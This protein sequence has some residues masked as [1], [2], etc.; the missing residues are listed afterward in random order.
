M[1]SFLSPNTPPPLLSPADKKQANKTQGQRIVQNYFNTPNKFI[2]PYL[3]NQK[4]KQ[5]L[6]QQINKITIP[7][8]DLLRIIKKI[9]KNKDLNENLEWKKFRNW[10]LA[11]QKSNPIYNRLY[12]K[13][14]NTI[15][16]LKKKV[17]K[18]KVQQKPRHNKDNKITE[19][20][21]LYLKFMTNI[22]SFNQADE[23]QI[24]QL[25]TKI[26]SD[27]EAYKQTKSL[28]QHFKET[29]TRSKKNNQH[30]PKS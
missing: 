29:Y 20:N 4:I 6:I 16:I 8:Q 7:S 10:Y 5:S 26:Q 23:N 22:V 25:I 11:N 18:K 27:A 9:E 13:A 14:L 30:L 19:F 2:D 15:P 24:N 28:I 17:N 12:Y 21:K 3:T 1:W